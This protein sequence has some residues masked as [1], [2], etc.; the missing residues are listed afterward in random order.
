VPRQYPTGA[1]SVLRR[2]SYNI[3]PPDMVGLAPGAH[4]EGI[5]RRGDRDD[6]D[7]LLSEVGEVLD[8]AGHVVDG[9]GGREGACRVQL[10][11]ENTGPGK[12]NTHPA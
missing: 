12:G 3:I 7:A 4:D 2:S 6:V 11:A 9:A 8:V 1:L 10:S 5:V